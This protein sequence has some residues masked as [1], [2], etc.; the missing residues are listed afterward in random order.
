MRLLLLALLALLALAA[1]ESS[2]GGGGTPG[3]GPD[4]QAPAGT[5]ALWISHESVAQFATIPTESL[6]AVRA[7]RHFYGHTS[8]GGQ[9]MSGLGML[10]AESGDYRQPPIDE[11]NGDLG[12]RGELGWADTTRAAL[13]AQSYDVVLWSWCGGVSDN[14]EAGIDAYL[15]EMVRLEAEFPTTTFVYMTG[16]LDGSGEAGT[17]R[18]LNTRIRDFCL[19]NG[20]VLFDF[21]DIESWDPAGNYYPD[22]AD[23]CAWC[24]RWCENHACA[25]CAWCAHSHCF[26]C[27]RKGQAFWVLLAR[28]AGWQPETETGAP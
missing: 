9:L 24:E 13:A 5:D 22:A 21:A 18:R 27:Y 10:Y 6:D 23:D 4:I 14:T 12:Q 3:P 2:A 25:D 8:H 11:V 1:C 26:N 15:D 7:R 16:H 17:L 28:L 20:K 19:A